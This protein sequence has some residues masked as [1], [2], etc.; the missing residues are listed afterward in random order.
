MAEKRN[1]T[2]DIFLIREQQVERIFSDNTRINRFVVS[3][4]I[5]KCLQL[6][7]ACYGKNS[8]LYNC[9]TDGIFI[10]NPA[11]KL[12]NKKDVKFNT[13]HIGKAFV[14]DSWLCYFEKHYRD[15]MNMEDYKIKLGEPCVF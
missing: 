10:T 14:T 4:A 5:L 15:N 8:V 3:Q 13:K 2:I 7:H 6:I 11:I 12:K 1:V 9:N